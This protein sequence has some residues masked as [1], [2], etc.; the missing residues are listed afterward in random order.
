MQ[1]DNLRCQG[2]RIPALG[3]R[4]S[5]RR[6][7]WLLCLSTEGFK[8]RPWPRCDS[9]IQASIVKGSSLNAL[10]DYRSLMSLGTLENGRRTL[11]LDLEACRASGELA[12]VNR[13]C[14]R[15]AR[16]L[17]DEMPRRIS[18]PL[19]GNLLLA[20]YLRNGRTEDAAQM[21][22]EMP[23]RDLISW[24]TMAAGWVR[25][26]RPNQA[27]ALFGRLLGSGIEPDGF[28]F[29]VVL[30]A[31]ARAGAL[32]LGQQ[33]HDLM[34]SNQVE[35]N[36]ILS[37]ALIDMYS[38]CGKI[39]LA[40]RVF[41]TAA[42]TDASVWNSMISGLAIH[43][44]GREALQLF[45][46]MLNEG[47]AA[48]PDAI[49]FVGLLTACSHCALPRKEHYAAVVDLLARAGRLEEAHRATRALPVPPDAAVWRALL[50]GCRK[51]GRR[52]DIAAAAT[53]QMGAARCSG[54]YVML[55]GL[56]SA[57][58]RWRCAEAVW[59]KMKTDRI[60]K[61]PGISC[62][63]LGGRVCEFQ[64]GER[65]R[66]LPEAEEI[67][68]G[69]GFAPTA[70]TVV[71]DL[72]EEDKEANLVSHSEKIAVAYAVIKTAPGAEIRVSKNLRT[73]EDC[74]SWLKATSK[75]LG[76]E[77]IVRDRTRFHHFGRGSCSCNDYW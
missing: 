26:S 48:A 62:V 2:L 58:G 44:H 37:S 54:D 61:P 20:A 32:A 71:M 69:V 25:V 75:I 43:G 49:T 21:F 41:E 3:R 19:P 24:N 56:Y 33:V 67:R 10:S 12:P 13:H 57:A 8:E 47:G 52:P 63:E 1:T 42:R 76:R 60:R 27:M 55:S 15:E 31:C 6:L 35:M 50:S 46:R 7:L 70:E 14:L 65:W 53:A 30:S 66:A 38:K 59:R 17:F 4:C 18:D 72:L 23:A 9:A 34:Q 39:D 28:T 29:S 45:D 16:S 51:H 74:H 64:A 68:R 36:P 40:R 5:S 73:C 11:W 22:D 77:I